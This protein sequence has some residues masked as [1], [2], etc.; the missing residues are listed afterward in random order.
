M[1]CAN[2]GAEIKLGCVYCSVCGKEAQ[3]VPDYNV[4]EDIL[5][6][7][8]EEDDKP[9]KNVSSNEKKKKS[10]KNSQKKKKQKRLLIT[11]SVLIAIAIIG[12]IIVLLVQNSHKK[13]FD[14]QYQK[15]ISYTEEKN[16]TKALTYFEQAEKLQPDNVDVLLRMADLYRLRKDETSE[17]AYL[18][19]I[20]TLDK[21]NEE[22]YQMLIALYDK[23]KEYDKLQDLYEQSDSDKIKSLFDNYEVKAPE[24]SEEAG[25]YNDTIEI[26]LMADSDCTIIIR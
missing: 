8:L 18:L 3:I 9:D 1:K 19:Q 17:E 20:L 5:K 26:E 14:Y 16:Y 15:G 11:V 22:A 21:N 23:Q 24:F 4:E 12:V 10:L 25:E 6:E 13:S 2:C 7:L